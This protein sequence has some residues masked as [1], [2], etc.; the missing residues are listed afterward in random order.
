MEVTI[1][2]PHCRMELEAPAELEGKP[3]ICPNCQE[4]FLVQPIDAAATVN[5]PIE[6][7]S[8]TPPVEPTP[9]EE[10]PQKKKKR[11]F[12]NE[13]KAN[14][15]SPEPEPDAKPQTEPRVGTP[16]F[17]GLDANLLA[18]LQGDTATHEAT[19]SNSLPPTQ[20][21]VPQAPVNPP[22][23]RNLRPER[24][25]KKTARL[26][27]GEV[28]ESWLPLGND[29]QLPQLVV[30]DEQLKESKP[31]ESTESNPLVLVI[32]LV[33]SV[34]MSLL[35]LFVPEQLPTSNHS[36]T[37]SLD[38]LEQNYI[39]TKQPLEPYQILVRSA[40]EL[41]NEGERREAKEVYRKLLDMLHAERR[42]P[43]EYLTGPPFSSREPNDR[44][45]ENHLRVLLSHR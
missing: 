36:M 29:G 33:V 27:T 1:Q 9:I 7:P 10:P 24:R 6:V 3:A 12:K 19:D 13:S 45:F 2:C 4:Q 31:R 37:D 23:T 42:N 5:S 25:Q 26:L 34:A 14:S 38:A 43:N 21:E 44:S 18:E 17:K 30:K 15:S 41:E 32:V 28:A 11:R 8:N 20:T 39:G 22:A 35:L 40:L 16:R